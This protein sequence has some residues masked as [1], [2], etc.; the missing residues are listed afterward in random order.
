MRRIHLLLRKGR[1]EF[2]EGI[3]PFLAFGLVSGIPAYDK[4]EWSVCPTHPRNFH[5]QERATDTCPEFCLTR[6]L[7]SG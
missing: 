7:Q 2:C 4:A 5:W 1:V 3:K 6:E